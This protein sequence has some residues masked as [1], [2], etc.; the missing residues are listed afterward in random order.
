LVRPERKEK[1]G[2]ILLPETSWLA[3]S[4]QGIVLAVGPGQY[5]EKYNKV[6]P[7][8]V[9]LGDK[10]FFKKGYGCEVEEND[11]KL[12]ILTVREVIAYI[13]K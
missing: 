7:L 8:E 13:P 12:L 2:N 1:V 5:S 10:V 11:E 3:E 4:N 9:E 6:I